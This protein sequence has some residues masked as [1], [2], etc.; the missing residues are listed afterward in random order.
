MGALEEGRKCFETSRPTLGRSVCFPIALADEKRPPLIPARNDNI[1]TE[2]IKR[3]NFQF[4][5]PLRSSTHRSMWKWP[6]GFS[7]V[8]SYKDLEGE[9]ITFL[10][11]LHGP[12]HVPDIEYRE[13]STR[14]FCRKLSS[15]SLRWEEERP[16]V[17]PPLLLLHSF[18]FPCLRSSPHPTSFSISPIST[19]FPFPCP[20]LNSWR[21][22]HS[23][24]V[25]LILK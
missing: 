19:S 25:L 24:L 15:K 10:D 6:C 9:P 23:P 17:L 4:V 20:Q 11:T 18:F 2:E 14:D 5:P 3:K 7:C 8:A 13:G 22:G 21:M 1:C 12:A 16:F